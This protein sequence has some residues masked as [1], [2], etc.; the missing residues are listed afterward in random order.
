MRWIV[1]GCAALMAAV[2]PL[3]AEAAVGVI[4]ETVDLRDLGPGGGQDVPPFSPAYSVE[5]AEGDTLDLT[6]D[7][8]GDQSLTLDGLTSVWAFSYALEP[9]DVIGTGAI[10]LLDASGNAFLTSTA[11]TNMEGVA[12]F[13]QFV[14]GSEFVGLPASVTFYGVRYVGVVDDYVDP[15]VT[16][17]TYY[18]P[19]FYY[20]AGAATVTGGPMGVPEPA[21]WGLMILGFGL[22]GTSLRGRRRFAA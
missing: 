16:S 9:T 11:K 18:S 3:A 21:A 19:A 4:S 17:R 12:H 22:A 10:S 8:A 6:I 13:G 15:A 20:Q 1:G 14:F 7:F 2:A 5:I